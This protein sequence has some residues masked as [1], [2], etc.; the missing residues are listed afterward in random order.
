[1]N[2]SADSFNNNDLQERTFCFNITSSKLKELYE[3]T[4]TSDL[5]SIAIASISAY[6][7]LMKYMADGY[8]VAVVPKDLQDITKKITFLDLSELG[9]R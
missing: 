6:Y 4:E 1:M 2:D 7:T 5:D 9:D 8:S 3:L